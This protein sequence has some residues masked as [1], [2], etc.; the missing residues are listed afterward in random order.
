M[1]DIFFALFTSAVDMYWGSYD[2][3]GLGPSEPKKGDY[4]MKRKKTSSQASK[5]RCYQNST[6]RLADM[7]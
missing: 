6:D 5:R 4:M 7:G 1:V 3:I 2:L